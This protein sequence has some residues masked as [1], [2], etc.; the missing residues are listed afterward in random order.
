MGTKLQNTHLSIKK[1]LFLCFIAIGLTPAKMHSQ[2]GTCAASETLIVDG[3]CDTSASISDITQD[4]PTISS[5]PGPSC[6]TGTFRR[7]GWYTFTVA[8]GP[9]NITITAVSTNR[10]LF[11]QLISS[12]GSCAGLSQIG[13][14]NSDTNGNTAQTETITASL[15]TGTYYIKVV[16][17]G[18]NNNMTLSS[19]CVTSVTAPT[20]ATCATATSLPCGTTNMAGTTVGTTGATAHGTACTMSNYGVWYTFTGD[21]QQTTISSTA[22]SG[23]D[24]EMAISSGNCGSFTNIACQDNAL[25]GGTESYTFTSV[26]GTPYYVYIAYWSSS[27][28]TTGTFTISRSCTAA[29]P[30]P[31]NA[32]CATATSLPCGTTNLAG[33]TVGTTG[34]TAHG[35]GCSMSNYGV[36]YTFTGDG[37]ET[38]ISTNPA[39]DIKLSVATGACGSLTNIACT[40]T[41]PETATF[42]TT[43]GVTYYVYIAYWSSSGNTTGTFTISRSCSPPFNPCSSIPNIAS[44]GTTI[45]ATIASG[46]GQYSP[47][48]CGW[49]TPGQEQIYTFTPST[50]GSYYIQQLS[51]FGYID[52]Q[53]KQ[54][55]TGCNGSGWTCIDDISGAGTSPFFTM[56]A[57][58]Q[59]YILLDPESATGGSI[60]FIL[61]CP[62]S[63]PT[64]D[65]CSGAIALTVNPTLACVTST[66]GSTL[67]A[68]QSQAGCS[69][70]AD[71]DVWYTFT[72]TGTTHT[73]TAVPTGISD[74]VMEIFSGACGSLTSI[75]CVD[76]TISANEAVQLTGLT[77]GNTYFVRIHSY[78]NGTGQGSFTLCVTTAVPCTPGPGTGISNACMSVIS[79]GFGLNGADPAP[80]NSCT[81]SACT[82]L[83]ATYINLG[84]TTNYTVQTIPFNPPYQ[85]SCLQNP[86]S[87]NVDDVWSQIINLPFNF[88][89]YGNSYNQCLIG[90]NGVITFDT[91]NNTPGGYCA[92]SFSNDLP[93]PTHFLNTIFGVYHD[94]D[95]SKGGEIGWELVTMNTGCR[96]LVAGWDNIPMFS[97]SCN[98][99][100]YS[101]MIVLYEDTNIIE[102]YIQNKE[103]CATWNSGNAIVGV[104][105]SNGTLGVVAPNRNA[106]SPDWTTY[107]EAWRFTPSG[108]SITTFRWHSGSGTSG[109]VIATTPV[110]TVCPSST[111][112]YTAEVTYTLCNGSTLVLTDET[113]VTVTIGKTWNGSVDTDWNKANNWTPVGIPNATDCVV[114]PSTSNNPIISGS[115]YVGLAG[116]LSVLNGATL[117]VLSGNYL[118]V[119]NQISV[120]P[121]GNIIINDDASLVQVSNPGIPNSGNIQV[122]RTTNIRMLDYVYWSSPVANFPSS[123]ISPLTPT[124]YIWKWNPTI[125]GNDYGIWVNGNEAMAIGKGYIVRGPSTYTSTPAP[126]TTTLTGVPNNGTIT[127]LINRGTRTSSYPSPGG[128]ATAEDDNWNLLGNPYPSAI[129][130]DLF[131]TTNSSIDGNIRLWTHGLPIST[132]YS[133]PFYE[134]YMYNYSVNDYIS[135]NL[136]GSTP[137]GFNGKIASCQSFFVQMLHSSPT[138][139][140]VTFNNTMR[141]STTNNSQFYRNSNPEPIQQESDKSRIWLNITDCNENTST[142]LFGYAEGATYERDRLFDAF[143]KPSTILEIFSLIDDKPM[144]IQ[145]RTSP[146]DQNDMVPIGY[147]APQNGIYSI[148]ILQTDGLFADSSQ[149]IYLEDMTTNTIFN[150]RN[151]P[152]YFSTLAGT[153]LNRFRIRYTPVTLNNNSFETNTVQVVVNDYIYVNSSN[154]A[155]SEITVYNVL[156]QSIAHFKTV[157]DLNFIIRNLQKNDTTLFLEIRTEGGGISIKKIVY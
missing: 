18:N 22:G 114:I 43:A 35:T 149:M 59:Y 66:S 26:V 110:V 76:D 145:G 85:F 131:I 61:G 1:F 124:G 105:N 102:V 20:N 77:A 82:D 10:N 156:G 141:S 91:T 15:T 134:D 64:N 58:V 128:T 143:Y 63:T 39:F 95:P 83:E 37:Q 17:V 121:S 29:P 57:G 79:G 8:S 103:V 21:G 108:P 93:S 24:H 71:D 153:N 62:V 60:S 13:C 157:N 16:N 150:L 34:A 146:L 120:S 132:S 9:Q 84:N 5:T 14:A 136:L 151:T 41:S 116:T 109:P 51:S 65:N 19:I 4:A 78:G 7:E 6:A 139:S 30:V 119:T 112:T 52:Y 80:I 104:Q 123:S 144:I 107:N 38:T 32:S 55:S 127:T 28:N 25:S 130:A 86:V 113:T 2:G 46:N 138:P 40:D 155:I 99:I 100:L 44:C 126:Y 92:W 154:E 140:A 45:N 12:T 36:W 47:S 31:P 48:S 75:D 115:G 137:P 88:C 97:S 142:T 69:G 72:A 42:I 27:G 87:V 74:I 70:T 89:F 96:A 111:T 152:Y 148:G 147:T 94:I 133:D 129:D 106:T 125:N 90:S 135:Y 67:A 98:S 33:T 73:V 101:G 54:S 81:G 11:L 3:A 118:T 117:T 50:T 68:T 53:I 23:F 122:I 56:T 49:T